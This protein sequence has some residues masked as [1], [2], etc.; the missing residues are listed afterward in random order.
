MDSVLFQV[1]AEKIK[2]FSQERSHSMSFLSSLFSRKKK[3][4]EAEIHPDIK[5]ALSLMQLSEIGR[6]AVESLN[7][8]HV[9]FSA[10]DSAS[11]R[12]AVNPAER[13]VAVS[14]RQNPADIAVALVGAARR[15]EHA[16]V[17]PVS[18]LTKMKCADGVKCMRAMEADVQA[19]EALMCHALQAM[20]LP[21]FE[22]SVPGTMAFHSVLIA[23]AFRKSKEQTLSNA[24]IAFYNCD[25]SLEACDNK[26][27]S[28]MIRQGR[29][30]P[31]SSKADI[32]S[33]DM[34][35]GTCERLCSTGGKSYMA[36][37]FFERSPSNFIAAATRGHI[38]MLARRFALAG[39][40][41]ADESILSM[42]TRQE[43][44]NAA[45]EAEKRAVLLQKLKPRNH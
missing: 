25:Q 11:V 41:P 1:Y 31:G 23:S 28:H 29:P 43:A 34:P 27:I 38:S 17:C 4:P 3:T 45:K 36:P 37:G 42:K 12:A 24:V 20:K 26:Y 9:R 39:G 7:R 40:R 5:S 33:E 19:H 16:D 10:E 21:G 6:E 30:A 35:A 14:I 13:Y 2:F 8:H 15:F 18:D 32:F 44:F 22:P